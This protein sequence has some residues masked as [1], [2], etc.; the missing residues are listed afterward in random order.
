MKKYLDW[1]WAWIREASAP[2]GWRGVVAALLM[3]VVTDSL[4]LGMRYIQELP[5]VAVTFLLSI[6]VS[7][8]RWGLLA[9]AITSIG[10]VVVVRA[11]AACRRRRARSTDIGARPTIAVKRDM[12]ADRLM[13]A[14]CARLCTV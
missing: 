1:A 9:G 7:A 12:N 11:R 14:H 13:P 6:L 8:I 3:V 4:L 10:V 5:P 2:G